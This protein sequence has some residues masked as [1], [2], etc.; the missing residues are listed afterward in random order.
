[1]SGYAAVR[2]LPAGQTA[3]RLS[4]W[5]TDYLRTAALADLGCAVAGVLIA[6]QIR[7]GD[8][9]TGTYLGLSLGLPLLWLAALWLAGGYDVRFIGVG[10]DEYRKVLNAGV[11]LTVAAIATFSYVVK[12]ELS[13]AHLLIALPLTTVLG[14]VS[15]YGL[16]KRLHPRR[17]SGRYTL[18][19]IAVGHERA[20]AGLVTEL[21]RDRY[22]RWESG[23][24]DAPAES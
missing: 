22:Q 24:K 1:M 20:V 8:H 4:S 12:I 2:D 18:S 16:R 10:S 15:R 14:L 11:G 3:R 21:G 13:R 19:V 17:A 6:A 9:V 23:F 7:F 5:A